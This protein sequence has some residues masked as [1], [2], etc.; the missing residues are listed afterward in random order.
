M[1]RKF[2]EKDL[3][4]TNLKDILKDVDI[5]INCIGVD[6]NNSKNFK[7]TKKANFDIPMKLFEISNQ[8]KVKYF[9]FYL[10]FSCLRANT[11]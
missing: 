11:F 6:I 7:K 3:N 9:F 2:P 1:L 8:V 10:N 5:V 4:K